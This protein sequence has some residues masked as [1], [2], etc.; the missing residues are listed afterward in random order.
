MFRNLPNA[1]MRRFEGDSRQCEEIVSIPHYVW[2]RE[3]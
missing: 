1:T 3:G 2:C